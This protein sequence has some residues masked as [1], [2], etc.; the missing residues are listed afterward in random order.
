LHD[1]ADRDE[2]TDWPL[3]LALYGL[4]EQMTGNPVVS[5]NRAIAAAMVHATT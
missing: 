4:L 3:I 2:D 1:R 5:L